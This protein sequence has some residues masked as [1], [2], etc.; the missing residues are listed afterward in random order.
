[1]DALIGEI[2]VTEKELAFLQEHPEVEADR[3]HVRKYLRDLQL[4]L[5]HYESARKGPLDPGP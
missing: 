5:A 1:M 3:R 4:E 2:G